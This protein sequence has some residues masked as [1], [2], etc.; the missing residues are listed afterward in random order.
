[1]ARE[2][3]FG[4]AENAATSS[5]ALRAGQASAHLNGGMAGHAPTITAKRPNGAVP[6]TLRSWNV[7]DAVMIS[8]AAYVGEPQRIC[9]VDAARNCFFRK[10]KR[11]ASGL[12]RLSCVTTAARNY[13]SKEVEDASEYIEYGGLDSAGYVP[14]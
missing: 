12:A 14:K 10:A 4:T 8:R 11:F 6:A 1:M 5:M 2:Q 9:A 7:P 13:R 3:G